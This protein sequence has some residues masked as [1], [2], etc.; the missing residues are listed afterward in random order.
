MRVEIGVFFAEGP[1]TEEDALRRHRACCAGIAAEPEEPVSAPHLD[2]FLDDLTERYPALDSLTADQREQSPWARRFDVNGD[3]AV[4][5]LNGRKC[6]EAVDLI[7]NLAERHGLVCF[8]PGTRSI[9]SAPPG[10]QVED[11]AGRAV[12][13]L[14]LATLS[15]A[16]IGVLLPH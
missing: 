4:I 13:P 12:W 15:L 3:Q 1:L 7:M 16:L 11:P 10:V 2:P 5:T 6:A 8:D 9:L 14:V